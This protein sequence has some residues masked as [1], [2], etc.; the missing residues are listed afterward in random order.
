MRQPAKD[1]DSH[2]VKAISMA[3]LDVSELDA[4]KKMME[5]SE[6]MQESL[7]KVEATVAANAAAPKTADEIGGSAPL[8]GWDAVKK[9]F[10]GE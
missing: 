2:S 4:S 8:N 9:Y 6:A 10:K 7:K 1:A 5:Q 3:F